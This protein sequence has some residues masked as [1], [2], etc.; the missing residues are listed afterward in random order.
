[1]KT[2]RP[3]ILL[4]TSDQQRWDTLGAYGRSKCR[5]PHLDRLAGDGVLCER[6]YCTNPLCSPSRLSMITGQNPSR[7]GVYTLGVYALP[8]Y[9]NLIGDLLAANGYQTAL[10]G[11]AHFNPCAGSPVSLES[12]PRSKD[13]EFFRQWHGP[14]YGFEHVELCIGHTTEGSACG[15]HYGVWLEDEMGINVS[16]YFG[17]KDQSYR[18]IGRWEL[19]EECHNSRWVADR[20]IAFIE[21]ANRGKRPF[22]AFASFQDPHNPVRVPEPWYSM[23]DRGEMPDYTYREGENANKPPFY[24]EFIETACYHGGT[25]P[26]QGLDG[27]PCTGRQITRGETK[28]VD[29]FD[30]DRLENRR[31]AVAVYYGMISLMDH[32]IGRIIECLKTT[33]QYENTLIV[34]TSDHGEYLGNHG[35][36]W[37]GLQAY[38]DCHRVPFLAAWPARIAMGR[39]SSALISLVDLAPTFCE[40]AGL[41]VPRTYQGVSQLPV[42]AGKKGCAREWAQIELRPNDSAFY[43]KTIVTDR[44]KL[45]T[46]HGQPYGELYD[47]VRDPDQY[48]N[49]W[50]EADAA[51]TKASLLQRM[52]EAEWDNGTARRPRECVA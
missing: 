27:Y 19:P 38:E 31:E 22:F 36:W 49:L 3:N 9:P 34:F 39:R 13:R 11:K 46:Y 15:M 8:T 2:D 1:M 25:V 30:Q 48:D 47:L 4:I 20:T 28:G 42:F 5:T 29:H 21:K 32:H 23:Y 10:L 51:E 7:H 26:A 16:H 50:S 52:L 43:Q 12:T 37:K 41:P 35:L 45:V 14:Y 17:R 24:Q 18:G 40:A 33:G 6:A 44:Y